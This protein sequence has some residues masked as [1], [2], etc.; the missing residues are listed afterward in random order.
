MLFPRIVD[1]AKKILFSHLITLKGA[2]LKTND[3]TPIPLSRFGPKYILYIC[4]K[5]FR[6]AP[7]LGNTAARRV[8]VV[9]VKYFRNSSDAC[10]VK[11][12]IKALKE[13][14]HI[15]KTIF[16]IIMDLP[17]SFNIGSKEPGPD[18]PIVVGCISAYGVSMIVSFI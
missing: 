7:G 3:G 17:V 15:L 18:G 14:P 5:N 6:N 10:S 13:G 16:R 11:M 1:R 2:L 9:T 8:R 12:H 4:P